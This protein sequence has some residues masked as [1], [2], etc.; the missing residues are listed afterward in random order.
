MMKIGLIIFLIIVAGA[1]CSA[2]Y[3]QYSQYNY[4][5]QRVN[6][7]MVA[8][9]DYAS[10]GFIFRNQ[11]TGASDIHLK[12]N[13]VSVAYPFLS[14]KHGRRWSGIGLSL[15]DDRS[16]SIFTAQ[17][18][19]ISYAI[20]IFL[21]RFQSLSLGFKGLYLLRKVNLN[22][23]FTGSQYIRDRGFDESMFNGENLG[24]LR[25][26]FFT[27]SSGLYWQQSDRQ[28][29][30][31]AYWG[32]SIFDLN[33][34]GDSFSGYDG[35][36]QATWVASGGVT[37]VRQQNIAIRPEFLFTH[38][39]ASK[40]LNLGATTSYEI[41]PYP[42]QI[43]GRI[44]LI[45]KY[46]PGRSGILGL[47]FH[48][49]H[50][51]IGFSYDFPVVQT[52]PGNMGA[53]ELGLQLRKLVDPELRKKIS[54]RNR[55]AAR[56]KTTAK[57]QT[58]KPLSRTDERASRPV[59]T[60]ESRIEIES[61]PPDVGRSLRQK[62]DSVIAR[63]QA[64]ALSQE[65]FVI[66]KLTLR[67]NFEF[68]STKL[69]EA[70]MKYLDELSGALKEDEHMEIRLTGHTDNVGSPAFNLRLSF[71]RANVIR[72]YLLER[73][74]ESSRI[75]L[76]GKGLTEP[77]NENKTEAQRAENRRVELIIYYQK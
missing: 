59:E 28:G 44:D 56:A 10:A 7:G 32:I 54:R 14:R 20:N 52:N 57:K 64:G 26:D 76:Q 45:T 41:K 29:R 40:V 15:M 4:T 35:Q 9:S 22:G 63:A 61:D 74:V 36:L 46:V 23:L 13:M 68:N 31:I 21:N 70:S 66:E 72:E 6:P 33:Q 3:F 24:L 53:F 1:H 73:G 65:P 38:S 25:S 77:L 60:N 17:E 51:S 48:R 16:G 75:E 8:S 71:F 30:Q 50:F 69:D 34:P 55:V 19:S 62:R 67:F 2:Q 18:A 37:V 58:E 49:D 42:N 43:A 27:F 5:N 12:S 39:P 47:Q 11:S